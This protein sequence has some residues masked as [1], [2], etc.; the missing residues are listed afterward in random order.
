MNLKN[1]RK[2]KIV[3]TIGPASGSAAVIERL[4]RA[5]MNV[6]RLNMSHGTHDEHREKLRLIRKASEKLGVPVAVLQDLSGPKIRLGEIP[7]KGVKL[8]PGQEIA[9]SG[10]RERTAD[11]VLP[12]DYGRLA[13]DVNK[14]DTVLLAD[15]DIELRVTAVERGLVRCKVVVGGLVTSR[16]GVNIPTRGL[17][18]EGITEKDKRDLEFAKSEDVD[19]VALSFVRSAKDIKK[20]KGLLEDMGKPLP[21]IAKIEKPQALD[22]MDAIIE[23]SYGIMV[24]R[25]DLGV[26]IPLERVPV[27]QRELIGRANRA[28]KPVITATQMLR[29]MVDSKRPTRAEVSDVAGAIWDG[30]DAVMLSEETAAGRYPVDAV[31]VM[32]R[33]A[34]AVEDEIAKRAPVEEAYPARDPA[35]DAISFSAHL[36]AEELSARVIITPTRSGVTARRISRYRPDAPILALTPSVETLRKLALTWGAVPVLT[37]DL[38]DGEDVTD[39]ALE[40]AR[41]E[42]PLKKGDNIVITA[43]VSYHS[44]TTNTIR[45]EKF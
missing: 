25:G 17:S 30:T 44:G 13:R 3:C 22:D 14:G 29:S 28:G 34:R 21:V 37:P 8:R 39:K 33:V 6:A 35:P 42:L 23:E 4:L 24:A 1:I 12:V 43:G 45:I 40:W 19:L 41:S 36:M 26:E 27:V 11:G 16:K 38:T 15:G 32:S 20:L 2:T 7:G 5:G 9:L 31:K 18:I 10:G